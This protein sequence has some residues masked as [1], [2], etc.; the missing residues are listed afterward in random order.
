MSYK[1]LLGKLR[2]SFYYLITYSSIC[3]F[4]ISSNIKKKSK[5]VTA[6]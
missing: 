1:I 2:N 4:N 5:K 3:P 6:T